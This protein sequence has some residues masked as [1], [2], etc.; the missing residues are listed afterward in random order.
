M[1]MTKERLD[2]ITFWLKEQECFTPETDDLLSA[3][4]DSI[5]YREALREVLAL[6]PDQQLM[7][8]L[9]PDDQTKS[10]PCGIS[11]P[12]LTRDVKRWRAAL[13]GK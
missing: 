10:R 1:T 7:D 12:P 11:L 9:E 4:R 2:E 13:E 6:W 5:R 8:A 3:A